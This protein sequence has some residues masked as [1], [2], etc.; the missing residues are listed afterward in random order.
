MPIDM[1]WYDNNSLNVRLEKRIEEDDPYFNLI[2]TQWGE[3]LK[4][5]FA[6]LP[7]PDWTS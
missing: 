7:N 6:Q 4:R 5:V 3:G 2:H 1:I